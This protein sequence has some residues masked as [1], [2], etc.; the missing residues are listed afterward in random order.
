MLIDNDDDD[1]SGDHGD[2]HGIDNDEDNDFDGDDD[3]KSMPDRT[4][5]GLTSCCC[6]KI[7]PVKLRKKIVIGPVRR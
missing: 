3:D 4:L 7:K 1:H 5:P 6:F 2:D